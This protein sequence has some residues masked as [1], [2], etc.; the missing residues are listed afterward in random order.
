MNLPES[1]SSAALSR[2]VKTLLLHSRVLLEMLRSG[3]VT[4]RERRRLRIYDFPFFAMVFMNHFL[5][6][7]ASCWVFCDV[8]FKRSIKSIMR[9]KCTREPSNFMDEQMK[10]H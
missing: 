6:R 9:N 1:F 2:H 8:V 4:R 10:L 7:I 3:N 5:L